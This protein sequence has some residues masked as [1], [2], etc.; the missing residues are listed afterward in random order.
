MT[1]VALCL[2]EGLAWTLLGLL[3]AWLCLPADW[4]TAN[5]QPFARKWDGGCSGW[6]Q[7]LSIQY[8]L[9]ELWHWW[10]YCTIAFILLRLHPAL[11]TVWS[12]KPTLLLMFL[13]IVG[14]GIGHLAEAYTVFNPIYPRLVAYKWINAAVGY[15]AAVMIAF[16][17]VMTFKQIE[18]K[19]KRLD[20][21][22]KNR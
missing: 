21:L 15:T 19:R 14:C 16:S 9:V 6:T 7:A 5:H 22:E 12:A 4:L 10:G 2:A 8:V 17:L 3:I 20:V 1:R 18:E 13:F 11:K